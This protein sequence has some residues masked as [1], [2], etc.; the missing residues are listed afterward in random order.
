MLFGPEPF[1]A[2]D[3][4]T[5]TSDR[6][7]ACSV[8]LVRVENGEIADVVYRLIRPPECTFEFT[9]IHGLTWEDVATAPMFRTVWP[10]IAPTLEGAAYLA[11]HNAPFDRTV[12]ESCCRAT[13]L[14]PPT[15]E[16]RCSMVMARQ[17]W[18]VYPTRLPDVCKHLDIPLA[19][20]DAKSDAIACARIMI[21]AEADLARRS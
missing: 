21:A 4:E 15:I 12:L 9:H 20:H 18:N 11:A 6:E 7:S 2:I 8:A 1:V 14:E 10:E 3:F 5:A 17:A 19:H 16:W 13:G